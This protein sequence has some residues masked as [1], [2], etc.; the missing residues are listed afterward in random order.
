M[1]FPVKWRKGME[2]ERLLRELVEAIDRRWDGES[3]RK[4]A[5]AISPRMEEAIEAAK[6]YLK[7]PAY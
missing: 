2:A 3:E 5:A 6:K 7:M 4:R 1:Y